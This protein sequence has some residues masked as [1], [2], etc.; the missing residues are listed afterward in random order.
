MFH[1]IF[2]LLFGCRHK[3]TTRPITPVHKLGTPPSDTYV[4]CLACGKRLRY[5]LATMSI[6][7]PISATAN[8]PARG[9]FQTSYD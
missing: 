8:S 6:G 4:A 5:D 9:A 3:K 1:E 7:K 2:D